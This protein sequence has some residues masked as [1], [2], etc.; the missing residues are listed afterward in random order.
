[1]TEEIDQLFDTYIDQ[2]FGGRFIENS[3]GALFVRNNSLDEVEDRAFKRKKS[4]NSLDDRRA[5]VVWHTQGSG[6]SFSKIELNK[7][8]N[9]KRTL[10]LRVTQKKPMNGTN[11]PWKM[12]A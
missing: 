11:L 9:G 1:M 6:K 2:E 12:T 3:R 8:R 4:V 7:V 10:T 5:G